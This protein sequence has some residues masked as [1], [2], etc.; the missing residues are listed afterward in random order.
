MKKFMHE[1]KEFAVKGN[2]IDMAVGIIVGG[3]FT[4][5]V[6]SIISNIIM[7]LIGI[8]VGVDFSTWEIA[9]PRLYGSAEPGT[10]AIGAFINSII[11]FIVIALVVFLF[12]RTMNNIRSKNEAPPTEPEP[13][14][15]SAEEKLLTEIR[16]ILS[17][18]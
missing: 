6:G 12:V 7:P 11:S 14:E 17:K 8:L 4:A 18:R 15:P 9:L 13:P 3:A 16:D 5:L 2:M 1:F 10:L